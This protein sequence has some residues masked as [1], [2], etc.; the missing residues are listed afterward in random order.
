MLEPDKK[1][2]VRDI[3]DVFE[4]I[5]GRW[6]GAILATLCNEPKRFSEIKKELEKIT[7]GILTKELR[8]L[9]TNEIIDVQRKSVARNSTVYYLSEHGKTLEPLI[10]KIHEWAKEHRK[11]VLDKIKNQDKNDLD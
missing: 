4:L 6:R 2:R 3:Q 8:Y 9:E 11:I 1:I 5:G 10:A 7:P